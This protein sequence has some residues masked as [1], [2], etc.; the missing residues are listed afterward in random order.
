MVNGFIFLK[1]FCFVVAVSD[2]PRIQSGGYAWSISTAK[3][4]DLIQKEQ[5]QQEIN[6]CTYE[7]HLVGKPKP[8]M[9]YL[10]NCS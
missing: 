3:C 2:Q 4:K 8:T 9:W 1:I 7:P 5:S 6:T 10:I